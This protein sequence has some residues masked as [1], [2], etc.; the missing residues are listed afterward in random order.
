[1][2][3]HYTW[4]YIQSLLWKIRN[5]QR[6]DT[7]SIS[8]WADFIVWFP[9]ENEQDFQDTYQLV[10]D[11]HINKLHIFPFSNHH[12]GEHVLASSYPNQVDE[13]IKKQRIEKL[14]WLWNK[15]RN[16]F[17]DSQ[18]W[19]TL[20][21]LIEK[22]KDGIFQWWSENYIECN[23][24]NFEVISWNIKKNELITGRLK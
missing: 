5:I 11:Y 2:K 16:D 12:F 20:T 10:E 3:R 21:V 24:N 8:I 4:E 9:W 13:K 22:I 6:S 18:K 23:S 1:M 19:K 17:I 7:I 15:I 14:T